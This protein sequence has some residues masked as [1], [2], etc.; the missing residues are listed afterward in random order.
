MENQDL[1]IFAG[2]GCRF[3]ITLDDETASLFADG[4]KAWFTVKRAFRETDEA[5]AVQATIGNGLE[6]GPLPH[7]L[8]LALT[9][10]QTRALGPARSWFYDVQVSVAGAPVET[11]A[12]GTLR[13]RPDVTLALA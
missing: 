13:V 11:V 12:H 1:E 8:T 7:Q 10:V 4:S 9:P 3:L 5:A 2:D 6:V